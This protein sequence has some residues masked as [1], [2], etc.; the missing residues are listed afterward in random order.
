[1]TTT[2]MNNSE[3]LAQSI[4]LDA[5]T[6][7]S[8]GNT[9]TS[10]ISFLNN[11]STTDMFLLLFKRVI[12][13]VLVFGAP[14]VY[15]PQ[16]LK[17]QKL[18]DSSGFS[19]YVCLALIVANVLRIL[20]WFG[21][22]YETPL[23]I[24]SSVMLMAMFVM[25][26][27]SVRM[28]RHNTQKSLRTSIWK[29]HFMTD[30]WQWTDL[31]SYFVA[32]AMFS[33]GASLLTAIFIQ[34]SWYVDGLGLVALLTEACLGVPQL[35]RNFQRKSTAGMSLPMVLGWLGGDIGKT[36]Y[37]Y[38]KDSPFQFKVCGFLQISVDILILLEVFMYRGNNRRHS[39]EASFSSKS[40]SIAE[41]P[42][43]S[44]NAFPE[45]N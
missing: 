16:Y 2:L 42:I 22:H 6:A 1:M 27:I 7:F 19:L 17:I 32:L 40:S 29:G 15:I 14:C 37:F 20:F 33:A 44:D 38:V 18:R 43:S 9:T 34:Y 28:K 11:L 13:L 31:P 30:F 12:E 26:E 5:T 3:I 10:T 25:L 41:L 4:S 35:L 39:D 21:N 45:Q 36:I 24:Q 8:T 23:L